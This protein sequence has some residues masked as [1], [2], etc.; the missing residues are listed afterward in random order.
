MS[1][2]KAFTLIELLIIIAII[3]I[4][5]VAITVSIISARTKAKDASFKTVVGSVQT[6]LVSCCINSGEALGS[7]VGGLICAG[8]NNYPDAASIGTIS[9]GNCGG[10]S[11]SKTITP[12]TKNSGNCT[13]ATITT[14]EITY[15]G[16][17]C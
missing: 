12:G 2:K 15:A 17:G 7:T 5:L 8:G 4:L 1:N 10:N 6:A 13:S 9:V 14:E 11:F 3:G 16:A